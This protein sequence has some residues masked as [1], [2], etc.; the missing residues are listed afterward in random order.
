M[1]TFAIF[2]CFQ[3]KLKAQQLPQDSFMDHTTCCT[4]RVVFDRELSS[5][6]WQ[7]AI[8]DKYQNLTFFS[9]TIIFLLLLRNI[10]VIYE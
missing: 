5:A 2:C 1:R 10:M 6:I 7:S 8:L 4:Y 3:I 9:C